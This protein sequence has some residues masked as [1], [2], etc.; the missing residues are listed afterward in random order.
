MIL[1]SAEKEENSLFCAQI[2]LGLSIFG[3]VKLPKTFNL[4]NI[5]DH[6]YYALEI[7]IQN[8]PK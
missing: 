2:P 6:P 4:D 5:G 7:D 3:N 1:K 8:S